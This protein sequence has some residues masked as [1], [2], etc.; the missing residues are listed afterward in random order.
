MAQWRSSRPSKKVCK[1]QFF[2]R[3]NENCIHSTASF[4]SLISGPNLAPAQPKLHVML[5]CRCFHRGVR[6]DCAAKPELVSKSPSFTVLWHSARSS[7]TPVLNVWAKYKKIRRDAD[8]I[9][10]RLLL[11]GCR[12]AAAAATGMSGSIGSTWLLS[13]YCSAYFK[14]RDQEQGYLFQKK[15]SGVIHAHPTLITEVSLWIN[16]LCVSGCRYIHTYYIKSAW[17]FSRK[18]GQTLALIHAMD[19]CSHVFQHSDLA[20]QG[21][22]PEGRGVRYS[23]GGLNFGCPCSIADHS[24]TLLSTNCS[25]QWFRWCQQSD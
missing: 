24:S 18:K 5:P 2:Y 6:H 21:M 9:Q 7:F 23:V 10:V 12:Q 14:I 1:N 20:K 11:A 8:L 16:T 4:Q 19:I 3:I 17:F 22:E 15:I 13:H 25:R